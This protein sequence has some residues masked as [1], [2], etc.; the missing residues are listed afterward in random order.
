[1]TRGA[2]VM[3][4]VRPE[5]IR[6]EPPGAVTTNDAV[7][8]LPATVNEIVYAGNLCDVFLNVGE[9]SVRAQVHP[10]SMEGFVASDRVSV[11]FGARSVWPVPRDS[12]SSTTAV[13]DAA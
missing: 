10:F 7:A 8:A 2:K 5:S 4:S 6:I 13:D 11:V 3:L 12:D 1:V 9:Y